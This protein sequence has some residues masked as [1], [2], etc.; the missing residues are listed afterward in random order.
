LALADTPRKARTF[1]YPLSVFAG[2]YEDLTHGY[3][4]PFSV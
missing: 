1:G 3:K 4:T 2:K